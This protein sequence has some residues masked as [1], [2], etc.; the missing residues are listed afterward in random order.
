MPVYTYSCMNCDVDVEL[1]CNISARNNQMCEKCGNRLIRSIDSPG[2]VW[3]PTRN[4]GY[5][6]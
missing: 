4:N 3:S 6:V 2:M 1:M 5:S